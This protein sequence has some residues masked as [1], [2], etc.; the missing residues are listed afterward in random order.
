[1]PPAS[2]PPPPPPPSPPTPPSLPPPL[3]P[4]IPAPPSPPSPPRAPPPPTPIRTCESYGDPH[5]IPFHT[6]Q[7]KYD[8][9]GLG[10][11]TLLDTLL[12]SGERFTLQS[13]HCP[14][15]GAWSGLSSNAAVAMRYDAS[16][17]LIVGRNASI[18]GAAVVS[19]ATLLP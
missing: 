6:W 12:D 7:K 3:P 9:H 18:N 5:I 13:F 11:Y 16:T 17:V 19:E 8:L 14:A 4:Q 15:G 1:M 10:A 2:P